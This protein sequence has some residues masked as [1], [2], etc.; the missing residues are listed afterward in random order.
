MSGAIIQSGG[1][2]LATMSLANVLSRVN[3]IQ[4][5]MKNVMKEGTHFG[6]S[7]PGDTKRNLLKPGAE[8]L[9]VTFQ[10]YPEFEIEEQV[11]DS[12]HRNYNVRCILKHQGTGQIIGMGVGSCSTLESKYRY[13]KMARICPK[14]GKEAIIKGSDQYGGGWLCWK[15]KEGCGAKFADADKAIT[16]QPEGRKENEDPADQWNTCK[17]IAKKRALVDG[18]ITATAC[19]DMFTQDAED[20]S[21][22]LS[23]QK[24]KE[25]LERPAP[26]PAAT[27][28]KPSAPAAPPKAA[29]AR[30]VDEAPAVDIESQANAGEESQLPPAEQK[31]ALGSNGE[32]FIKGFEADCKKAK[33]REGVNEAWN[34]LVPAVMG[35]PKLDAKTKAEVQ[36]KCWEIKKAENMRFVNSQ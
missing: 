34:A 23:A 7:F 1:S 14:C 21:E 27:A 15:K 12:W 17:K 5:V 29:P 13:R 28:P 18:T 4:E 22:N 6:A 19:S 20:I 31:A 32:A 2:E 11:F 35:S 36:A 24:A 9:G 10:L 30:V 16:E 26:A 8:V 3:L 25:E 33:N